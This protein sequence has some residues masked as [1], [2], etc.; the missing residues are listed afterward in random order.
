MRIIRADPGKP[1]GWYAG[2]W[3]SRL[4]VSL[5]YANE[6]I[7]DPHVHTQVTEVYLVARGRSIIRVGQESIDLEAG[8]VV[9]VEPGEPHTFVFSSPDYFH[10]VLH[11][12]GL[13]GDEVYA[14]KHPVSR[15]QLGL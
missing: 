7:D 3:N 1:K 12:P 15:S 5:G 14:E 2:P 11:V 10:F 6:G 8:D 13:P 4:A 9:V